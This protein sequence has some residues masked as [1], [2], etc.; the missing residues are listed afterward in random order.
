MHRRLATL[1]EAPAPI[2]VTKIDLAKNKLGIKLA[3]FGDHF[4]EVVDAMADKLSK[5][6]FSISIDQKKKNMFIGFQTKNLLEENRKNSKIEFQNKIIKFADIYQAESEIKQGIPISNDAIVIMEAKNRDKIPAFIEINEARS[7]GF[8]AQKHEY[9]EP[10]SSIR[11]PNPI[12]IS[13]IVEQTTSQN[14]QETLSSKKIV[15]SWIEN[16][17][18]NLITDTSNIIVANPEVM[19]LDYSSSEDGEFQT[20]DMNMSEYGC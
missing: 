19:Q 12:Q 6:Q 16:N 14:F 17:P 11:N 20:S 8:N 10:A 13:S 9:E 15:E 7:Y 1:Q 3:Q 18:T 2:I 5:Y 4:E